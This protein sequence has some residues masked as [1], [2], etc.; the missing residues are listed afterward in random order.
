MGAGLQLSREGRAFDNEKLQQWLSNDNGTWG[1]RIIAG[2]GV[3][4]ACLSVGWII[5]QVMVGQHTATFNGGLAGSAMIFTIL[6]VSLYMFAC[7]NNR[8]ESS[9]INKVFVV[10]APITFCMTGILTTASCLGSSGHAM[11][12]LW[13]ISAWLSVPCG[14]IILYKVMTKC[15]VGRTANNGTLDLGA[16][17]QHKTVRWAGAFCGLFATVAVSA[18]CWGSLGSTTV[19]G[20]SV[21]F[22][23]AS[24]VV[25]TFALVVFFLST[26]KTCYFNPNRTG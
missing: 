1:E 4:G 11:E 8:M 26:C 3:L 7:M 5:N 17:I 23:I 12:A 14:F 25:G 6:F 15:L 18:R 24:A 16:G 20:P 19:L 9:S 13:G 22:G 2:T 21:G 10:G